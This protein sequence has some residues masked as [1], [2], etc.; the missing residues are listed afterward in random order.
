MPDTAA[1]PNIYSIALMDMLR[2]CGFSYWHIAT[3]SSYVR[4]VRIYGVAI[5]SIDRCPD[6][7][8]SFLSDSSKKRK[9]GIKEYVI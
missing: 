7:F 9:E 8:K 4:S 6:L 5:K 3:N 2:I 1:M